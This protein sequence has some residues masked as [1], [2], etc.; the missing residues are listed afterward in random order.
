MCGICG[1]IDYKNKIDSTKIDEM[2]NIIKHRGPDDF[3]VFGTDYFSAGMRRLSI[4]DITGGKQPIYNEDESIVTFYN[5]EIYN[6]VELKDELEKLGHRFKTNSDTEVIV[7]LYEQYGIKFIER[8]NGMFGIFLADMNLKEAYLIR[9]HFGIKPLYYSSVNSALIFGSELKSIL[10]SGYVTKDINKESIINYFNYLFIPSPKT[11]FA[12]IQKLEA[13]HY[14]KISNDGIIKNKWYE[15]NKFIEPSSNNY[16]DLKYEIRALLEDSIK[17]Q[18]RSDVPVGAFLSGGIDSSVITAIASKSTNIPINTFSVGFK[19]SEFD[20]LPYARKVSELYKTKHHELIVSSEDAIKE[21][22]NLMWYMDEPI[23]DSAVLPSYLVSKLAVSQVKVALSGLGGDELFGGYNRYKPFKSKMERLSF[24][25]KIV[26]KVIKPLMKN[27]VAGYEKHVDNLY[28]SN[29]EKYHNQ[30]SQ[31]SPEMIIKLTKD[32]NVKKFYGNDLTYTYNKYKGADVL[33]QRMFTDIQLYMN[34][35]LLHLTDRVSMA[36]SLE[37]RVPFLDHRLVELSLAVPSKFKINLN[38]TKLI[39][40]DSIKD[41]LPADILY[42]PKWGFA[43]P[44]KTWTLTNAMKE[45]IKQTIEGDLVTDGILDKKG[46]EDFLGNHEM[47]ERY[48]TWVWPIIALELWYAN[49]K[50][51]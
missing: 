35:Q 9:D 20:E 2:L 24:V 42:R 37:T 12:N 21:L 4:I 36:N 33:N 49:Y 44:Y 8:L 1:I 22:S 27:V 5:G 39:L 38:D 31:M 34:D 23:G 51:I 50:K 26:F 11:A 14:L 15:L 10:K 17:L 19:P 3:G 32:N 16:E 7:H 25:P 30:V 48:S 28:S 40:K 18:M 41:L 29:S 43:A 6:Y 46:I 45:L 13:G 47:I